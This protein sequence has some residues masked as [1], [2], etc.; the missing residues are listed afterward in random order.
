MVL[1]EV[2]VSVGEAEER[3]QRREATTE[4]T[5]ASAPPARS[6]GSELV[7]VFT[8][9]ASPGS[10]RRRLEPEGLLTV[11]RAV[12]E[13]GLSLA[14]PRLSRLHFRVAW[15]GRAR[16]YRVGDAASR[17]GL[18]VN[19]RR[20]AG[21]LLSPG[22][23]IRAGDSLFVYDEPDAERRATELAARAASSELGILLLGE[24]GVGKDRLA[25]QIHVS[26]K[27]TG[28]F[29]AVN[30]AAIPAS[31]AA[32]EL[33]GHTRTAFSGATQAR[34]GLFVAAQGGTILLDEIGDM[35]LDLQ[36]LVLRALEERVVRPVGS[37][38]E[39]PIDVRVL[40]ATHQDLEARCQQGR[41]RPDLYA[42]L[43]Q[44]VLHVPPLRARRHRILE[45]SHT[46]SLR[47]LTLTA[48]GAEALLLWSWPRNVRELRALVNA[49]EIASSRPSLDLVYLE[50]AQPELAAPLVARRA[51]VACTSAG[52]APP[53]SDVGQARTA[54]RR[55]ARE[56]LKKLLVTNEGN[57]AAAARAL[58]STRAQVYRW[59]K[60]F[61]LSNPSRDARE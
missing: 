61:G 31:L 35:P 41:F 3:W 45:L 53:P 55:P 37:D 21:C 5:G 25:R 24:T 28:P 19:G 50:R 10:L 51:L 57:V 13:P 4:Q 43:A 40:A 7:V 36:P 15:D 59:M 44:I 30:C 60:S 26:S 33:F 11:G 18:F 52:S 38:H 49:F 56:E 22:D 2:S 42:R 14:D 46:F 58:G 9:G 47:G 54:S 27:R 1:K 29:I 48:D 12:D 6:L 34:D 8:A 16:A 17:N 20:Q 32:A 23:V 39:S